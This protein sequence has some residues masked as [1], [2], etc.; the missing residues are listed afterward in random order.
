MTIKSKIIKWISGLAVTCLILPV[1]F[2]FA[3]GNSGISEDVFGKE[4]GYFHPFISL[5]E[6]YNDN[7]YNTKTKEDDFI[8][9]IAPGL[10][11]ALPGTKEAITVQGVS[12]SIPGG[13]MNTRFKSETFNRYQAYALYSPQ[14]EIY[15]SNDD[16]N[17]TSH[18]AEGG[19]QYNLKGGLSFDVLDQYLKSHDSRGTGVSTALDEY[20]NNLFDG[21]ISYEISPKLQ[22]RA[23]G[24]TYNVHY[25]ENRNNYKD[26]QDVGFSGY[27]FYNIMSKTSIYAGYDHINVD[28]DDDS[29]TSL[30]DSSLNRYFTGIK[31]EITAKS[32]GNI[33]AGYV[34][35][36]FDKD[37]KN[38]FDGFMTEIVLDH[39]FTSSTGISCRGAKSNQESDIVGSSYIDSTMLGFAYNQKITTKIMAS[40]ELR[41]ENLDYN[42]ISRTDDIYLISPKLQYKFTDWL[43]SDLVYSY[44]TRDSK[45]DS[46][47]NYDYE[48]NS[49]MIKITAAI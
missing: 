48:N 35:R 17:A 15:S 27:L 32:K 38:D 33:K 20:E 26:R 46:T 43:T 4:S 7:I 25:I 10:W 22:I 16:E 31:W 36:D 21:M 14:F 13:L 9:V 42:N 3:E 30:S 29:S 1:S 28:Y 34:T 23:G 44:K 18:L 47:I 6:T 45:S 41:W 37:T 11:I 12:G 49:Y 5:S 24:S 8:T 39:N 2:S 19:L 40:L